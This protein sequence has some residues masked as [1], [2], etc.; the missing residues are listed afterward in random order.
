M[1]FWISVC[2]SLCRVVTAQHGMTGQ[3]REVPVNGTE[4]VAAARFAVVEFNRDNAEDQFAYKILNITSAKIQVTLNSGVDVA[5]TL[6]FFLKTPVNEFSSQ[7]VAG[8]NLILEVRLGRTACK[9]SDTSDG[10]ACGFNS[11]HKASSI[12]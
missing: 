11:E 12:F 9:S 6:F 3:P 1:W 2:A 7:V 5:L 4:V 8:I 10:E